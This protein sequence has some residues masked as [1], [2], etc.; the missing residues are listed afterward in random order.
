MTASFPSLGSADLAPVFDAIRSRL[1]RSGEARRGRM[2]LPEGVSKRA[3]SLLEALVDSQVRRSVDLEVLERKLVD[4]GVARDLPSALAALG[5]PVSEE[6]ARRRAARRQSLDARGAARAEVESWDLDWGR[7]WLDSIVATGIFSGLDSSEAVGLVS[8]T[9][10]ILARI[11]SSDDPDGPDCADRGDRG[12]RVDRGDRPSR[13]D[14]AAGLLG[15]SHALDWGTRHSQAV[16]RA[17]SIRFGGEGREAWERAGVNLDRVSAPALTWGLTSV[18]SGGLAHLMEEA[19]EL[20]V[21]LHLS[22]LALRQYPVKVESGC[23]VLVTENPRMVEAACDRRTSY[24]VI[25]LNGNP[26]S[27]ALLL[28]DQLLS[29]GAKLRYHGDFDASGLQ[30]CARMHR[31]GLV[32]WRMGSEAYLDALAAAESNGATLPTD[33]RRSPPTPWSSD[34]QHVFDKHRL[35]VHEERLIQSLLI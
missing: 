24:P 26:S 5:H 32:P 1:E 31:L 10:D 6:P 11:D 3:I 28:V 34:M 23:D 15:D 8:A 9:R 4:L 30:I 7:Q 21:P 29:G 18:T 19:N 16:T 12:D 20:G 14:L 27:A 22:L 13:V 35:V 33:T 2:R 17:L 25:A